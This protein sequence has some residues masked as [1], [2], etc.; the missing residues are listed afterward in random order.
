M[1]DFLERYGAQLQAAQRSS[2]SASKTSTR[3][4]RRAIVASVAVL[5]LAAPA[6]AVVQPWSPNVGRPGIDEPT[7]SSSAPI[8]SSATSVMAVLRREQTEADR[9]AAGPLLKGV[10]GNQTD[11]VQT[12]GIR[13]LADGWI[14]VPAARVKTGPDT[15]SANQLCFTDGTALTCGPATGVAHAGIT[16]SSTDSRSTEQTGLVPDGVARVRFLPDG[17]APVEA[18]VTSNFFKLVVSQIAPP[19]TMK[20]PEG[21]KGPSEIPAPPTPLPGHFEWL[22]ADGEVVG[23]SSH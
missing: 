18:A 17:A 12:A 1:S 5:A 4:G 13:S 11:G 2:P 19:R 6:L 15:T 8:A 22:N 21:F 7:S 16:G 14:L 3:T 10:F 23:P 20:A 9:A